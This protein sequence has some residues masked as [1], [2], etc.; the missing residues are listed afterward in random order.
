MKWRE[1]TMYECPYCRD[2]SEKQ[3]P[4]CEECAEKVQP[5][6]GKTDIEEILSKYVDKKSM[7]ELSGNVWPDIVDAMK[8][9]ALQV[10]REAVEEN[11]RELNRIEGMNRASILDILISVSEKHGISSYI[12]RSKS[13]KAYIVRARVDYI[14]QAHRAGYTHKEI[15]V[16]INRDR[17]TAT[18]HIKNYNE[19]A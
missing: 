18:E 3:H 9:Y 1:V 11:K 13:R 8:E 6:S 14:I 16:V 15:A 10:A 4:I 17:S 5:E 2:L 19:T 12:I 7:D